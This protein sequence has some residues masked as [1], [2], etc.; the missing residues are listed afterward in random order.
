[1][2]EHW[3]LGL[4]SVF[5]SK[6]AKAIF[7]GLNPEDKDN[8]L[9]SKI[10]DKI[11]SPEYWERERVLR[12]DDSLKVTEITAKQVELVVG[13]LKN[14]PFG[15]YACLKYPGLF[16]E[17]GVLDAALVKVTKD[18]IYDFVVARKENYKHVAD[19]VDEYQLEPQMNKKTLAT[20]KAIMKQAKEY[21]SAQRKPPIDSKDLVT[22]IK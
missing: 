5:Q 7:K 17:H 16:F 2:Q 18:D 1:M 21:E 13:E 4:T 22:L 10:V 3:D 9:F 12:G 6:T 11:T 19:Y 8:F 14:K 20:F 15:N